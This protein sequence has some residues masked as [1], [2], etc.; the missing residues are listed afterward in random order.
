MPRNRRTFIKRHIDEYCEN[1]SLAGVKYV[2][3]K[4][5]SVFERAWWMI[6]I[7][8]SFLLSLYL[9]RGLW[10]KW[11]DSPVIVSFAE[12]ST[13]VWE[14]PFPAVTI[15]SS[16][17]VRRS[18]FN[19][20]K[21][22]EMDDY[23]L[24]EDERRKL[25]SVDLLCLKPDENGEE[26]INESRIDS[27]EE[28]VTEE[29]IK[30]CA[31][32]NG[33]NINCSNRFTPI[34]TDRGYCFTSNSL[35]HSDIYHEDGLNSKYL[36]SLPNAIHWDLEKG[37]DNK[38]PLNMSYPLRVNNSGKKLGLSILMMMNTSEYDMLCSGF[39][40]GFT[41]TLHNPAEIA[42]VSDRYFD[43]PL[44]QK[45][46]L[47][48]K[49]NMMTTSSNLRN[50]SPERRQCYFAHE[51]KLAFFKVYT[52]NNCEMECQTNYSLKECGCVWF[53]MPRAKDTP[54]CGGKRHDCVLFKA[55]EKR[56]TDE[57]HAKFNNEVGSTCNCL[58]SCTS[59]AYEAETSQGN[60]MDIKDLMVLLDHPQLG[61]QDIVSS[62]HWWQR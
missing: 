23:E 11:N 1:S 15:C 40:K 59:L 57:I 27:L 29:F 25:S 58:Q 31:W 39:L 41:V 42:P 32:G 16:S 36:K 33:L 38:A 9:I 6:A 55:F 5:R 50:Y 4:D 45:V 13:S 26:L 47:A 19:Y 53:H 18:V 60:I 52:Q 37:Y 17:R 49:P 10:V 28:V 12:K 62:L 43:V 61:A 24:T 46:S 7:T 14:I 30:I 34:M 56:I 3:A 2:V 20:T 51:R 22:Y 21:Y 8:C 44:N 54:I 48:V 35:S